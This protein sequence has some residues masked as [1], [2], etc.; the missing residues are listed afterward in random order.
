MRERE[1]EIARKGVGN[2]SERESGR[3]RTGEPERE[4]E[5]GRAREGERKS[6]RVA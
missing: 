4:S 5:S 6:E 2:E 3:A 1:R